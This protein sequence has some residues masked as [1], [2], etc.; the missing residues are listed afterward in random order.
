MWAEKLASMMSFPSAVDRCAGIGIRAGSGAVF[1]SPSE[2]VTVRSKP[3]NR[4]CIC[5]YSRSVI[6]RCCVIVAG[7]QQTV[8]FKTVV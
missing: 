1:T 4:P 2:Q 5:A 7:F 3:V 6:L 8:Q